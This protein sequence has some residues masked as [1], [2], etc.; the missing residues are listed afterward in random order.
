[1]ATI[2]KFKRYEQLGLTIY[3]MEAAGDGLPMHTHRGDSHITVVARGS[4]KVVT[5]KWEK[6][7]KPGDIMD[8]KD[9]Q[10]H[11]ITALEPDTR[12][13]NIMKQYVD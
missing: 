11:S 10:P 2:P 8:F 6:V 7:L 1:M 13:L 3:D 4:V 9:F 12:I 5:D